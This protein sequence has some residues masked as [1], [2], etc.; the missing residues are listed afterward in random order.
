MSNKATRSAREGCDF[1]PARSLAVRR[2]GWS[3]AGAVGAAGAAIVAMLLGSVAPAAAADSDVLPGQTYPGDPAGDGPY[4]ASWDSVDQHTPSPE[5]FKDAKFGVYWHWGAFGVPETGS[6]WYGRYAYLGGGLEDFHNR[7]FGNLRDTGPDGYGYEKF[8]TGG[9]DKNG[10]WRQFAPKLTSE[11]GQFDPKAWMDV[12]AKSGAKFAGPVAEHHDGFSMWDSQVNEWNSVDMGPKLDLVK[13]WG[14]EV[15]SHDM[16]YLVA[17]HHAF[18]MNGFFSGAPTMPDDSRKK[19]FGQLPR[20]EENQLWY[21]K[22]REVVDQSEPDIVWQDFGLALDDPNCNVYLGRPRCEVDE[23]QRLNFFSYYFNQAEKLNKEVV[24]TYKHFDR[25]ANDLGEVADFERGGPADLTYP[26]WLTDDSVGTG[27][28]SWEQGMGYYNST[29]MIHSLLDRVSKNGNMLLNI[30]P[31]LDGTI[32]AEQQQILLDMGQYLERNGEAVYNTRAWDV[33]GEGPTK[34]GGGSFVRPVAGNA[35]DIRYTA[36]KDDSKLY[37]TVLG[38]PGDN[39]TVALT[40]LGGSSVDLSGLTDVTLFGEDAGDRIPLDWSQDQGALRVQMP[41]SAPAQEQAY[42]IELGFADG[43]PVVNGNDR[44]ALYSAENGRGSGISIP[45]GDQEGR[46]LKDRGLEGSAIESLRIGAGVKVSTFASDDMTGEATVYEGIDGV[47]TPKTPI[48]S[49]RVEKVATTTVNAVSANAN[50]L[51]WD[52]NGA[53][54]PGSPVVQKTASGSAEQTWE[55]VPTSDGYVRL[56]NP[57]TGL[58]ITSPQDQRDIAVTLAEV[59]ADDPAQEWM[60]TGSNTSLI[61]VNRAHDTKALDSGGNVPSGSNLKQWDNTGHPNLAFSTVPAGNPLAGTWRITADANGLAWDSNGSTTSGT[62]VLQN[63][64]SLDDAQ[65]WTFQATSDGYYRLVNAASGRVIESVTTQ[66]GSAVQLKDVSDT[67]SQQWKPVP[68][69]SS[70]VFQN[71]TDASIVLDSGGSVP[72]GSPLKQ[73]NDNGSTNFRFSLTEVTAQ[74]DLTVETPAERAFGAAGSVKVTV[75]GTDGTPSG[76]VSVWNGDARLAGPVALAGGAATLTL[77]GDA[78]PVGSHS[79]RVQYD[80][81][82]PYS[83]VITAKRVTITEATTPTPTP[84]PSPTVTPEPTA[85]PDPTLTPA[86]TTSPTIAP[87]P[88]ESA[89]TDALRGGITAPDVADAGST[90]TVKVGPA[91]SG[92]SV[93]GWLFSQPRT[94]GTA[95][96]AANGD[97]RLTIPADAPAGSHRI[98]VTDAAGVLI[99]W[100]PIEIRQPGGALA[101][102]GSVLP[103]SAL[104]LGAGLIAAGAWSIRRRRALRD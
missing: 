75:A 98:A 87:A 79:L 21:D 7:T 67:A 82:A 94:L 69:G 78:L 85:S 73:W 46:I 35:K 44:V 6:E 84:T 55:F 34:M 66:A 71:R 28:W 88:T 104:L 103:V 13:I 45:T 101:S 49:I 12:V 97:I 74:V 70:W 51:R 50:G 62:D 57:A 36:S 1:P 80:A 86:P 41:S 91:R 4:E 43:V 42:V 60:P 32:P 48:G 65:E 52:T 95:T 61:F 9:T 59:D 20:D 83:D 8:I 54:T 99:G 11:G 68:V 102:T 24:T 63:T 81:D 58:A 77:A 29:Q 92:Q 89:L 19:L 26:Y 56:V 10:N 17:M 39:G 47:V 23:Q 100:E 22:L 76:S 3:R 72:S 93:T 27:S 15:R 2:S 5:W 40:A 96:V 18:N 53:T 31:R 14:D 16:K 30:A 37:A 33:Y 25:G 90:I 64:A 38:W